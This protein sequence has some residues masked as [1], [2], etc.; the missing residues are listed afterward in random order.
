MQRENI[1][2]IEPEIALP[3]TALTCLNGLKHGG[4][5]RQLFV[6]GEHPQ[7]FYKLLAESF[8]THKPLTTEDSALVTDAVLA[9]WYLWR[10]Q[11]AHAKREFEIFDQADETDSPSLNGLRE[12]ELFDRYRTQAERALNRALK[13]LHMVKKSVLDEEKWRTHLVLAKQKFDLDLKKF[14]LRQEQGQSQSKRK[15][16]APHEEPFH[17]SD[18]KKYTVHKGQTCFIDQYVYVATAEDGAFSV[19]Y[20]PSNRAVQRIIENRASFTYPPETVARTFHFA[21][22]IVPAPFQWVAK[23]VAPEPAEPGNGPRVNMSFTEFLKHA[24]REEPL[25]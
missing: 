6:F 18:F 16:E 1:H 3:G 24:M 11:R 8:E 19:T 17:D 21:D 14:E 10:R 20:A 22:G 23:F 12:L 9:R 2:P 25:V 13:N 4:A 5:S 7:E 15:P